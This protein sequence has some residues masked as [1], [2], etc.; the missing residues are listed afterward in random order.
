MG[1]SINQSVKWIY[2]SE[3]GDYEKTSTV[4][5]RGLFLAEVAK[6]TYKPGSVQ[7]RAL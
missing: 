6:L 7:G 2:S 4:L 3:S 5:D 1:W